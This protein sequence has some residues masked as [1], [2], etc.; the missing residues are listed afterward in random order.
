MGF[1]FVGFFHYK[2]GV[3]QGGLASA[4]LFTVY[5]D[6][7]LHMLNVRQLGSHFDE[8]WLGAIICR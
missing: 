6:D 3:H 2:S 7:L 1:S 4:F 8:K 5:V